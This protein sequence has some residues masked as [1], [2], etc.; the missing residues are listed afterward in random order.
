MSQENSISEVKSSLDEL[1]IQKEVL[2][3]QL[4]K[5]KYEIRE[6]KSHLN[7]LKKDEK[8]KLL[9]IVQN[10]QNKEQEKLDGVLK[11]QLSNNDNKK[12]FRR[13]K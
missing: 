8:D 10:E 3:L 13:H 1:I 11:N 4:M 7:K 6:K 9:K 2:E 5:V 12:K